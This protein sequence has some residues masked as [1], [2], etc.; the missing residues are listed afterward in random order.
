MS[1]V[2]NGVEA[3]N[4]SFD[5]AIAASGGYVGFSS[6]ASI[7]VVGDTSGKLDVFVRTPPA[8][9]CSSATAGQTD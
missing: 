4:D 3:A 5:A 2:P 6:R 1:V 9:T 7:L 8:A